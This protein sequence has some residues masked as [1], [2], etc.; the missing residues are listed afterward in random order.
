MTQLLNG[1]LLS[2]QI[3]DEIKETVAQTTFPN[4]RPLHLAAILVGDD[5]ASRTYVNHK[6]KACEYVGM[7]STVLRF[8]QDITEDA[9]LGEVQK[10]NKDHSID[11]FIVQLP[12]PNHI[13]SNRVLQAIDPAKDVDGFHPINIGRMT[14]N[15]PS[16]L[17]ATPM[18]IITLLERNEIETSGKHCVVVG[19][20]NIV[21]RPMSILMSRSAKV[22]NCTVTLCHSR[23][24]DLEQHTKA[25]DILIVALGKAEFIDKQHVKEGAVVI[26]VGIT[27]IEDSIMKRGFRLVGDVHF[28]NVQEQC[29]WITPVPGGVGP[30]TV[31]SLLQ[32]TLLAA[33]K[34][35]Y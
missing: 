24:Q 34:A 27:R 18:G 28:D 5:G 3:K 25:A 31:V 19:R 7:N 6:I 22:G 14:L 35:V 8:D 30:M 9:L 13:N 32:N 1:K 16:Y 12:L 33:Q 23:T 26:D 10:L 2:Q 11:G 20:S 29:S 15:L 4:G 21:G 17:P